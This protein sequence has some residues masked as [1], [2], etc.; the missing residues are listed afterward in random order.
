MRWICFS[1]AALG[2]AVAFG[3]SGCGSSTTTK[4][5]TS[6]TAAT[7]HD[8]ASREPGDNAIANHAESSAANAKITAAPAK[9]SA[10]DKTLAEKQEF[11]PVSGELL[12]TMGAPIKIDVKGQPVFICCDGCKEKLLSTPDEYLAK[13]KK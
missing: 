6:T 11:C 10:E 8:K 12:G 1:T 13:L 3:H 7:A 5:T 4:N 2:L 9:L